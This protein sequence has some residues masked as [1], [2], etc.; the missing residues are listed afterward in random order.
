[1]RV[2][3]RRF[4]FPL[5]PG[6]SEAVHLAPPP[7]PTSPPRKTPAPWRLQPPRLRPA[8]TRMDPDPDLTKSNLLTRSRGRVL[9]SPSARYAY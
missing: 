4:F 5:D 1:M 8:A 9:I 6:Q 7:I 2:R 3:A